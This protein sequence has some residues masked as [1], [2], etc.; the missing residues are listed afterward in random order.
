MNLKNTINKT[1]VINLKPRQDRWSQIKKDFKNIDLQLNRWNA[2]DGSKLSENSINKITTPLCNQFC[3]NGIIGCWLSHFNIWKSI[4]KNKETNV[5]ILEDDAIPIDNFEKEFLQGYNDLPNDWDLV[6]L[7]CYG[8]CENNKFSN[9]FYEFLSNSKNTELDI[10]NYN[11]KF[12]FKPCFPLHMHAYLISY[13]GAL[14][15]INNKA[16][17]K[18][19]YHI[20]YTLSKSIISNKNINF[21]M[22]AFKKPIVTQ[23]I[24]SEYSNLQMNTHPIIAKYGS[25][26]KF[27]DFYTLDSIGS[28]V[29]FSLRKYGLKINVFM[30]AMT[31][32]SFLLSF[33]NYNTIKTLNIISCIYIIEYITN[34]S[35]NQNQFDI[36][37]FEI[38]L[39]YASFY[40]GQ[41]LRKILFI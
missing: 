35:K 13:Q 15:L 14:K 4:V 23:N 21:N 34:K 24:S 5:L 30:V 31:I 33:I 17:Q 26:I 6:F 11:S 36:L 37:V 18:V 22:F 25:I 38:F 32:L 8:S 1:Y 28:I 19:S 10:N 2:T 27:S 41:Q 9:I 12:L 7:G 39:L 29:V 3:T 40:I 20:D 16:L